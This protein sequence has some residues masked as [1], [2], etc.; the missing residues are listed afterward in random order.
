MYL[1]QSQ[2]K[3]QQSSSW[4]LTFKQCHASK[5]EVGSGGKKKKAKVV[6]Q[7]DKCSETFKHPKE[8]QF[9][10]NLIYSHEKRKMKSL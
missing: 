10:E 8:Q 5:R 7:A 9:W 3:A 1:L 4:L 2:L 6:E